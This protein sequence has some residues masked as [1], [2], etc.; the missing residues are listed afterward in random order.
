MFVPFDSLPDHARIWIYQ[1][2]RKIT[3]D[4][5]TIISEGLQAFTHQ[6]TVHGQPMDASFVVLHDH[7]II[8]AA[9][10]QASGCSIDSSVRAIKSLGDQLHIDFFNRNL[11]AFQKSNGVTTVMLQD[12]K[13]KFEEGTWNQDSLVF[14]N[15]VNT[16]K[17]LEKNW[18][19]TAGASWLKRYLPRETVAG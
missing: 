19:I 12:L 3:S 6:W 9:N 17:E 1:S 7:F 11:I 13:K 15:L 4:E 10:D 8:L 18:L 5:K 2:E 14:N 16:K